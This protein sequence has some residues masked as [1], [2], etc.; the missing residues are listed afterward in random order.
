MSEFIIDLAACR[1]RQARLLEAMQTFKVDL[2]IVTRIET[3][4]WL[5]G[6]RTAWQFEP[7]AAL[8]SDGHC[9]LVAP[10]RKPPTEFAADEL[11]TYEAQWV[12][13]LRNDQRAASSEALLKAFQGKLRSSMRNWS[14]SSRR[15][16]ACGAARKR[17]NW[18]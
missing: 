16:I 8:T 1:R 6:V 18:H 9:T 17:T 3:V 7:A 14:T 2:V 10:G 11:V 12:S 4:Q 15:F 13:T 5:T